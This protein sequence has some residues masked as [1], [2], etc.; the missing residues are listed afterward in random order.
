MGSYTPPSEK[1]AV[2]MGNEITGVDQVTIGQV[3]HIIHIPMLGTKESLN[4]GQ[5]AAIMMRAIDHP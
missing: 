1:I 2:I 5:A 4:V 3:D